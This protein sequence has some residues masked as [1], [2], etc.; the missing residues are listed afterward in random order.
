MKKAKK[1]YLCLEKYTY[2]DD[3]GKAQEAIQKYI[4]T[5]NPLKKE[6]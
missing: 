1:L 2:T 3:E 6:K 4:G 5:I